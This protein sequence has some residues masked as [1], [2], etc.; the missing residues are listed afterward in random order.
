MCSDDDD[1]DDD[2]DDGTPVCSAMAEG[3]KREQAEF[4]PPFALSA[5]YTRRRIEK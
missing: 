3:W 5:T 1:D 2:D 4:T